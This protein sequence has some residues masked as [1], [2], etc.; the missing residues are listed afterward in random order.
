MAIILTET[1]E[2]LTNSDLIRTAARQLGE[3]EAAVSAAIS[4]AGMAILARLS[5]VSG[6]ANVMARVAPLIEAPG[7]DAATGVGAAATAAS[8]L[9]RGT[10]LLN[11]VY[12]PR[13]Q[14]FVEALAGYASISQP[15]ARAA[16]GHAAPLVLKAL[17]E[18]LSEYDP[19]MAGLAPTPAQLADVLIRERDT[20]ALDVPP[21]LMA[22]LDKPA[23]QVRPVAAGP[24]GARA[25]TPRI[26]P[27]G[28]YQS[29]T[30]SEASRTATSTTTAP[31]EPPVRAATANYELDGASLSAPTL[32]GGLVALAFLW[33]LFLPG[34]Y[35][36]YTLRVSPATDSFSR[37]ADQRGGDRDRVSAPRPPVTGPDTQAGGSFSSST[38]TTPSSRPLP[39]PVTN[40]IRLIKRTLPSN[41]QIDFAEEGIEGRLIQLIENRGLPLDRN[42]WFDF[43]RLNFQTGS[44]NLTAESRAQV[45]NIADILA[46]YPA[47][48]I[49]IGGY[50][51]NVGEPLANQRLSEA[52]AQRVMTELITL[53]I[54]ALRLDAEGYGEQHPVS[55]NTTSEGRTRNRR[56]A[57]RVTER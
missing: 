46:S 4:G 32:I 53:G 1:Y 54:N 49:K 55:D 22:A 25:G 20:I 50:T 33:W 47:V 16:I 52:R 27:Q 24:M 10:A 34:L 5:Q 40:L 11:I 56:I 2:S 17:G 38:S 31:S 15:S 41:K 37:S 42:Q 18:R 13:L 26:T 19:G 36:P 35:A 57:V 51:D 44:S 9:G 45:Q 23:V 3:S 29:R 21:V 43:D 12:G 14:G 39:A 6:D 28:G 8:R 30:S 48:K 7:G